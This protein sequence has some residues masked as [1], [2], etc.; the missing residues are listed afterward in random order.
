MQRRD[1]GFWEAVLDKAPLGTRYAYR[2]DG[3]RDLPD[4]ASRFQPEGVHSPSEVVESAFDWQDGAWRGL[5]LGQCVFYELHVGTFTAEGTFD[6]ARPHLAYL[7]DLGVNFVE[8]MPVAQFPG[9][10]NWGY[11]GVFPFA[12]QN[13]YG[14]PTGLRG[15][16]NAC[17]KCG[18]GVALDVVY[19][20]LGP[21]GNYLGEF[22]PYFTDNYR[23]PWGAA[24]NFDG[25]DSDEVRRFFLE[26]AFYWIREFHIDAL[27]LDAVHGIFDRSAYPFLEELGDAVHQEASRLNRQVHV[28]PE[29]D[30][31]DPRIVRSKDLGGFGLDAQ[32]DDD[33]HHA[34][35]VLV[36]GEKCGY[37]EDFGE[38]RHLAK[39]FEHGYV[40]SGEYSRF[41][42]R[43]HGASSQ[44]IPAQ[45]FVVCSQNHDQV[46]NRMFG[47]RLSAL[48][49]FEDQ[50]LAAAA[51]ILSPHVPLL[52]MG[53]EYAETAPFLYFVSHSEQ[54]LIEA[55]RQ[56]RRMEFA[57]FARQGE[58]PDPQAEETFLRSKLNPELRHQ[59]P[60]KMMSRYYRE[61]LRLR[62]EVPALATL[63]RERTSVAAD[64]A[65]NA[66]FIRRWHGDEEVIL[67]LSFANACVRATTP[68]P[69]GR[70]EKLLDSADASWLGPGSALPERM[71]SP[72]IVELAL[73]PRSAVLYRQR[74]E[75]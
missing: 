13:T 47:E 51:V 14:G 24:I 65:A 56:G 52:F 39:A 62:R 22:G 55:V 28:I 64:E 27:R 16:V 35:R 59:D 49:S 46:G 18:L 34:L 43:R 21:E 74:L 17:H 25:P 2:I 6:A 44:N 40:Y 67:A 50:K 61:L 3:Q 11:D 53:E 45:R 72:G 73:N 12:A 19:N 26:N 10:R 30:L 63:S 54:Q 15:F 36:T 37:Y 68:W 69:A 23:T 4:P 33:F 29:S 38:L 5:P 7:R 75:I 1:G 60:H 70:W 20:H 48:V 58:P 66:L 41:R 42:R 31:N 9:S 32:W 8:L 71:D 57:V